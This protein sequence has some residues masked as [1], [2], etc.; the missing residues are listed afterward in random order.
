[1]ALAV[2]FRRSEPGAIRDEVNAT[3]GR[4][5]QKSYRPLAA[6]EEIRQR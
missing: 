2:R 1:M 6:G 3:H 4:L 5:S